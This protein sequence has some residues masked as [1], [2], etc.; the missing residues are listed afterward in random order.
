MSYAFHL[1]TT[2]ILAACALDVFLG[3]PKWLPHPVVLI[4]RIAGWGEEM[5]WRHDGQRNIW[6]G[7]ALVVFVLSIV[8][9]ITLLL[10]IILTRIAWWLGAAAAIVISWTTIAARG[11]DDA[12][13]AIETWLSAK[14]LAGARSAMPALVGRDPEA[15][16]CEAMIRATIESL[17]E[18]ASDAIVAPLMYLFIAGPVGAM[19]YKVINTLDSM[20]GY[21]TDRY[22]YFGRVAARLDDLAN[23]L[24]SRIT[25]GCI[26]IAATLLNGRGRSSLASCFKDAS[27]HAS[28]NAGW[29]EAA[30][31]GALGVQ[32]GGAAIYDGQ[33][34]P[35]AFLGDDDRAMEVSDIRLARRMVRVSAIVA[36]A[37]IALCRYVIVSI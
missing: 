19:T 23:L 6:R 3:D 27:K 8:A 2:E 28:P 24:P 18:N 34:E 9:T 12:A 1:S 32:L 36:L 31:A 22:I 29:P 26:A 4:G 35:R 30:M 15:L 13:L 17:A 16:D 25:A 37:V 20:I 33:A 11:L 21:R 5:I 10:I 7:A 14:D